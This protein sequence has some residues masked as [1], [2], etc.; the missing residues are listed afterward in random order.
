VKKL[1]N[2]SSN[3]GLGGVWPNLGAVV[4]D[5]KNLAGFDLSS[6]V[7]TNAK[8][9]GADLSGANLTGALLRADFTNANLSG[10]NMS[11]VNASLANV[12]GA[13]LSNANLSNAGLNSSFGWGSATLTGVI[14]SNT[15]CSDGTKSNTNGTSPQSCI[16]HLSP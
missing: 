7:L 1:I 13:N 12:T 15:T 5:A 3:C 11:C 2:V 14:W 9:R 10:A 4:L 8:L 16:G 6:V